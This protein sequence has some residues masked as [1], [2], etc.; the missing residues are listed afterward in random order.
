[1][2]ATCLSVRMYVQKA[3]LTTPKDLVEPTE[4]VFVKVF[5][6][7]IKFVLQISWKRGACLGPNGLY[8]C[9]GTNIQDI[10]DALGA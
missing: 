6:N 1:M 7:A 5:S 8:V 4:H 9:V 10:P 3:K 2:Y